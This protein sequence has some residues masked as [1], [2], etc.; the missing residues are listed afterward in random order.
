MSHKII[1]VGRDQSL[2]NSN[3]ILSKIN[4]AKALPLGSPVVGNCGFG[5]TLIKV[6]PDPITYLGI[7]IAIKMLSS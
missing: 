5:K 7:K 1:G 6:V 4:V 2:W 3:I